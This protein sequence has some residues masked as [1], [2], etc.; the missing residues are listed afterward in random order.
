[1]SRKRSHNQ[2]VHTSAEISPDEILLDAHN[3]PSFDAGRLEGRIE[4][5]ITESTFTVFGILLIAT[6]L[7]FL[8][9][10]GYLQIVDGA[11][12]R[13]RSAAN[14]LDYRVVF[15]PRGLIYDRNGVELAWNTQ[16]EG[17]GNS[18]FAT[19]AYG[20]TTGLAHVLGYVRLPAT[21]ASGKYYTED[22]TGVAGVELAYDDQLRGVN[23]L[24]IIETDARMDV[25]SR[26]V[27]E[28]ARPG[29][30]LTLTIDSRLQT[31]LHG[32]IQGLA[33]KIPFEGGAA[34]MMDVTTGEIIAMTS[35]PE[36]E[37]NAMLT[38]D[39]DKI[40]A[41]ANDP[42]TPYLNRVVAGH[43]TPGSIV[44]PF[45]AAAALNEGIVRPEKTFV[46]T[47]ALR[48]ANPYQPGQF[49]VFN[50]WRAHGVVDMRRALAVSSDEYFYIIGG[51]YKGQEGLGI[52]RLEKYAQR[53]GFGSLTG[54]TLL[55]ELPGVIPSPGWKAETFPDDPDWRL[56]NT[57]H[58][59]IGQYGFQVTP[60]QAARAI[61]AVANG[62]LLLTPRMSLVDPYQVSSVEIPDSYL[63][64]V[65]GGMRDAVLDGTSRALN[66]P[67][68]EVA[69][70]TGTAE[71]GVGKHY[72]N[73]WNT[74]IFP[75]DQPRYALVVMMERGPRDNLFGASLVS[76]EFID[77]L[78]VNAPEYL[79]EEK[80]E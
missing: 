57:Y 55:G 32:M 50:D 7:L 33:E 38:G 67:Y 27:L 1:M 35:F 65:R 54:I 26:G 74:A 30:S 34:V 62:G 79:G 52:T 73:S 43:Y 53:F 18:A 48:I 24:E 17:T 11:E 8:L 64:I 45:F 72:V 61:S 25:V 44:K 66:V 42:K 16:L 31:A 49:S 5:P 6:G 20:T 39:D 36:Y 28:P 75:Y 22:T 23:G 78:H 69:A 77:W 19:R 41:Y 12:Y 47:G 21:D 4:Q 46:S 56:G 70:K 14:T 80:E 37:L 51:G 60:L 3:L 2:F 40:R 71:V 15:A 13:D 29:K 76:R 9:R 63:A 10:I 59:A 68:L 58:T